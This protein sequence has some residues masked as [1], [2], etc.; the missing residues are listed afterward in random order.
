MQYPNY[1][2]YSELEKKWTA[3]LI[4][5][6]L[7][8]P[9][10]LAPNPYNSKWASMRLYLVERVRQVEDTQEFREDAAK[11]QKRRLGSL[12]GVATKKA[13]SAQQAGQELVVTGLDQITEAQ[14]IT[15]ACAHYNSLWLMEI[16]EGAKA[17]AT[18]ASSRMFL[19]RIIVNYVRHELSNYDDILDKLEGMTGKYEAQAIMRELVLSRLEE[20]GFS[21]LVA[22]YRE[23]QREPEALDL[24]PDH[25]LYLV[26]LDQHQ[27]QNPEAQ[28]P[29]PF[30]ELDEFAPDDD[31]LDDDSEVRAYE[32]GLKH[33]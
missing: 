20:Q 32:K 13:R 10:K 25:A 29:D 6:H 1:M 8:K 24:E 5:T 23:D 11:A 26:P 7:G 21:R 19:A 30:G 27:S 17:K 22:D 31:V 28:V 18:R 14:L 3:T 2:T 15:Q 16:K 9:D 12:R 4:S 33:L